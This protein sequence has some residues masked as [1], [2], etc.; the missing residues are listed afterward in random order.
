MLPLRPERIESPVTKTVLFYKTV[1]SFTSAIS[2]KPGLVGLFG[3]VTFINLAGSR[4]VGFY[5][6]FLKLVKNNFY[7]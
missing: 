5:Y 7:I 3:D 4:V 6:H 2:G 1:L